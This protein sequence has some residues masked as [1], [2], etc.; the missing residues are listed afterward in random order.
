MESGIQN[1][2]DRKLPVCSR[3]RISLEEISGH[4]IMAEEV[5]ASNKN[6]NRIMILKACVM[7]IQCMCCDIKGL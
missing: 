5:V 2:G 1:A 4:G 6:I 7:I 3:N